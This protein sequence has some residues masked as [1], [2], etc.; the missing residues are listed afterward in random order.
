MKKEE[1]SIAKIEDDVK[2]AGQS[3]IGLRME[4]LLSRL[5]ELED[6][7]TKNKL[8]EEYFE[9]QIGTRDNA[10]GGTRTRVNAAIRIIKA[11]KV[12][13]ALSLIDG[14][15]SRVLPEA[16]LGAKRVINRIKTGKIKLPVLLQFSENRNS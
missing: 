10:I 8:I 15:D 5:P 12:L 6:K 11:D 7:V 2:S 16:V 13:Y 1:R 9:N 3:F 4:D 14:S